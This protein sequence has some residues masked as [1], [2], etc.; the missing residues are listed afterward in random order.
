MD[1]RSVTLSPLTDATI[2]GLMFLKEND[3]KF[4]VNSTASQKSKDAYIDFLMEASAGR[5]ALKISLGE[6]TV[7]FIMLVGKDNRLVGGILPSYQRQGI[8]GKARNAV[9]KLLNDRGV[10]S[11]VFSV[12]ESN[13]QMEAF[14]RSTPCTPYHDGLRL[15]HYNP[16]AP[17]AAI[18]KDVIVG[19]RVSRIETVKT[20]LYH[21]SFNPNLPHELMPKLPDGGNEDVVLENGVRI[22]EPSV[23]R[24][25]FSPSPELCFRAIYPNISHLLEESDEKEITLYLYKLVSYPH[26]VM[27]YPDQMVK[28]HLV[29]DAHITLE[30]YVTAKCGIVPVGRITFNNTSDDEGLYYLPFADERNKPRFHSPKVI[31]VMS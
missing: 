13:R 28:S 7:G 24:V 6:T 19:K 12:H 10:Y 15:A 29:H 2:M 4:R 25:S 9:M 14:I 30:H 27:T 16:N 31:S 26:N 18:S 11:V 22:T 20:S 5:L 3:G 23:P 21:L 8:Y 1:T 17:V